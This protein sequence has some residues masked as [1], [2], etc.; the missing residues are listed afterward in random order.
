MIETPW[1]GIGS[2]YIA[3]AGKIGLGQPSNLLSNPFRL[4]ISFT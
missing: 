2:E 4:R 3:P 1:L